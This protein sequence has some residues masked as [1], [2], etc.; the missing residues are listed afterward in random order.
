MSSSLSPAPIDAA[1]D[2]PMDGLPLPFLRELIDGNGGE[3][4]QVTLAPI[5][6]FG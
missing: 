1:D 5:G 2:F 3:S 6:V 4:V